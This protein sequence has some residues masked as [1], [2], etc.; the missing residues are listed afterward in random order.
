M[1][2]K[3]RTRKNCLRTAGRRVLELDTWQIAVGIL[4][5]VEKQGSHIEVEFSFGRLSLPESQ[6][7]Q[8]ELEALKGTRVGIL[9]TD[10]SGK[11]FLVRS[12]PQQENN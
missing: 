10:L 1:K 8:E 9:R 11:E 5:K 7:V 12:L 3:E 6:V 2:R 4:E